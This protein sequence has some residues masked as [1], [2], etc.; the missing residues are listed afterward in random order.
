MASI[1]K[2]NLPSGEV[3]WLVD[4]QD[5]AGR[6]RAKQFKKRRDAETWRANTLVQVRQGTHVPDSEP[7]TVGD[8]AALW[9]ESCEARMEAGQEMERTTYISY[10]IHV[11][12]HIKDSDIGFE[13]T[14]LS[15]LNE[16]GVESFRDRLLKSGRSEAMTRKVLT[17]LKLIRDHAKRRQMIGSN[18][19]A[20][21]R[22]LR[23]KRTK[24]RIAIPS[25]EDVK[26]LIEAAPDDF[27]PHIMVAALCGLRASESRGL[28]W[29]SVD[30]DEGYI[31]VRQRADRF[32]K[33]GE[34]KSEAAVR[35]VPMGP[36]VA[37][38]LKRWKLRCPP[39]EMDLVFPN[40]IGGVLGY[41][42]MWERNFQTLLRK[43]KI[44]LRWH[45]LRHFAVSLWIEQG[46]PPKAI[47]EFAGHSSITM[48]FDTYGHL[49]P[50]PDHHDGMAE[51]E[52]RLF[53]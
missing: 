52:T 21:V 46:F 47:M 17:T 28:T 39:G 9:L 51:V 1:R 3:R 5:Q 36:V 20:G 14:K 50:S 38:T 29:A 42:N 16:T 18:P 13:R 22:V 11:R 45:D 2:R 15:R 43:L 32:N 24:T 33:I 37:N 25:K 19:A 26:A 34:P 6:R 8:A 30:F 31:H 7:F 44:K 49:F 27:K 12:R 53:G 48:T 35:S 10:E 23:T 40:T 41:Q 4:Y